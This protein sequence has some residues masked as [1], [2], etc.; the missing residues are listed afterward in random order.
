[1]AMV[2]RKCCADA[3]G[4]VSDLKARGETLP[5]SHIRC[6]GCDREWLITTDKYHFGGV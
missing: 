4:V 5:E 6:K 2:I 3:L 1:M